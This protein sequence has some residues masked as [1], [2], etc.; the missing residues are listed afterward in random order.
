MLYRFLFWSVIVGAASA[1]GLASWK[2]GQ[3]SA[4]GH[5]VEEWRSGPGDSYTTGRFKEDLVDRLNY[6][7]QAAKVPALKVD[8]ELDAW[9]EK[10]F[11]DMV[12]DDMTAVTKLVEESLPRYFRISVCT[13]S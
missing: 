12:L 4:W 8:P 9:L 10:Q 3:L 2:S 7:R 1:G 13:A 6:T 11:P 5:W